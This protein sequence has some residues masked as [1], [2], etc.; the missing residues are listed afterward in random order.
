MRDFVLVVPFLGTNTKF[1]LTIAVKRL[2]VITYGLLTCVYCNCCCKKGLWFY[3]TL[4][5]SPLLEFQ[6]SPLSHCGRPER[7]HV[8]SHLVQLH[9][10]LHWSHITA[11]HL[12]QLQWVLCWT[13]C[14][15]LGAWWVGCCSM[16]A[17]Q[18]SEH[19]YPT[20]NVARSTAL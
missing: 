12:S 13:I 9:S 6:N 1:L 5:K 7:C 18:V 16:F 19:C 15:E 4:L 8:M 2:F 3:R 10:I 17:V 14:C 11:D 20:Y